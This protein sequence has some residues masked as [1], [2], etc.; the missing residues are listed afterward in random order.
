MPLSQ[1]ALLSG[2]DTRTVVKIRGDIDARRS[3]GGSRVDMGELSPEARVVEMWLLKGEGD[4]PPDLAYGSPGSEFEKLVK[5]VVTSRG[6][7]VQSILER[8][9]STGTVQELSLIHI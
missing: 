5:E 1:L 3:T 9:V 8:L 4:A 7:T 6:V 2:L